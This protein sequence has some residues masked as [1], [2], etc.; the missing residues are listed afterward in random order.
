MYLIYN[1]V[2]RSTGNWYSTYNTIFRNATKPWSRLV[3]NWCLLFHRSNP[4]IAFNVSSVNTSLEGSYFNASKPT[5]FYFH[6]WMG[7]AY[8]GYATLL[9][10]AYLVSVS[11]YFNIARIFSELLLSISE[12]RAV[13]SSQAHPL[14]SERLSDQRFSSFLCVCVCV[15]VICVVSYC[16]TIA[17]GWKPICS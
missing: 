16:S 1:R 7:S 13:G 3:L 15:C 11:T 4:S 2:C 6:G 14:F 17:T 8:Q 10:H 9:A 5:M 12:K